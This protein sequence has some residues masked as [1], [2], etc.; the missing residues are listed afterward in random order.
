MK[1]DWVI[2]LFFFSEFY[3]WNSN[4]VVF[5]NLFTKNQTV[6]VNKC[7]YHTIECSFAGYQ[8][9]HVKLSVSTLSLSHYGHCSAAVKALDLESGIDNSNPYGFDVL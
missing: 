1:L 7:Y 4:Y 6:P 3:I 8:K 2:R 9:M 5:T